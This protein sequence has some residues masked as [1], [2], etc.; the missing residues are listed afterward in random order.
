VLV[1]SICSVAFDYTQSSAEKTTTSINTPQGYRGN[2][3]NDPM[4]WEIT[5]IRRYMRRK[6]SKLIL[7]SKLSLQGYVYLDKKKIN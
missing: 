2:N 3:E 5:V 6:E 4:A 7:K 1:I